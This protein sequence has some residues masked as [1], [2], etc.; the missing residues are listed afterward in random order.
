VARDE[1][2]HKR[3]KFYIA[4]DGMELIAVSSDR[5][6][7]MIVSGKLLGDDLLFSKY[8]GK[9]TKARNVK[10]IRSLITKAEAGA[11]LD[12]MEEEDSQEF[13]GNI[14]LKKVK[15]S[16]L[17]SDDATAITGSP[18]IVLDK[19]PK[20][21]PIIDIIKSKNDTW[22]PI[23][24]SPVNFRT[25]IK[26]LSVTVCLGVAILGSLILF[27]PKEA[28]SRITGT[29]TYQ[30]QLIED[31]IISFEGGGEM[32]PATT[33]IIENGKYDIKADSGVDSGE[34]TVRILGYR[35]PAGAPPRP[36]DEKAANDSEATEMYI[37]DEHNIA[38]KKLVTIYN[39]RLNKYD[40]DL[41][42]TPTK[43]K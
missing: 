14:N 21:R 37:P 33:G 2:R 28:V 10:G 4:K 20:R 22:S 12:E 32:A 34:M 40:F 17:D 36:R 29:V 24:E 42:Q 1:N 9:W 6:K 16:E 15:K 8:L 30:G 13:F 11:I 19:K 39:D 27:R 25:V 35:R 26:V 38:S 41:I 43:R 18:D 3:T 7:R 23:P 31:G 5:I